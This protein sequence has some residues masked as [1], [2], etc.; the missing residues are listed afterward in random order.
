[1]TSFAD[2]RLHHSREVGF[3]LFTDV[4]NQLME[5]LRGL[6]VPE[7]ISTGDILQQYTTHPSEDDIMTE[8][9]V[10]NRGNTPPFDSLGVST[11]SA[12]LFF[13][14][15]QF[16]GQ[17]LDT[18]RGHNNDITTELFHKQFGI[19][20]E[21]KIRAGDFYYDFGFD[22]TDFTWH[23]AP[24]VANSVVLEMAENGIISAEQQR[25]LTLGDWANIIRAGWFSSL[26][27]EMTSEKFGA[28]G[29]YGK[30]LA[31]F[32]DLELLDYLKMRARASR[33]SPVSIVGNAFQFATITE[34]GR[35][36]IAASLSDK[37]R[38]E[39]RA[40]MDDGMQSVETEKRGKTHGC[41]VARYAGTLAADAI[42]NDIH[43]QNLIVRGEIQVYPS[44]KPGRVRFRQE[45]T[46]IDN[47][48]RV[49]ADRLD[50]YDRTYG[51]PLI[52]HT[53]RETRVYHHY[54]PTADVLSRPVA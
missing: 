8:L 47:G 49:L 54:L 13:V 36:T 33:Y 34:D 15:R 10:R 20:D 38:H 25:Q 41:P 19:T 24:A 39:L 17:L 32:G 48:L 3:P 7:A 21:D 43:L 2:E 45:R 30:D 9:K 16:R 40:G 28:Y 6:P 26:M 53:K 37:T 27:Q 51:T 23:F 42:E 44:S 12:A 35:E 14:A 22:D 46:T 18:T 5:Y 29:R 52:S 1:M 50:L 31:N 11:S 4:N